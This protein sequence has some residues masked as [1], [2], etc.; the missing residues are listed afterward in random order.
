LVTG[1]NLALSGAS[2]ETA[3]I[4]ERTLQ[5]KISMPLHFSRHSSALPV[6]GGQPKALF[7]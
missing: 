6:E 3:L 4:A 2:S 5:K 7:L 1:Q